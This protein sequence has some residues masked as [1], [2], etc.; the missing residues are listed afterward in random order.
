MLDNSVKHCSGQNRNGDTM[1]TTI[2]ITI[3]ED[4]LTT[5][6]VDG[7]MFFIKQNGHVVDNPDDN[8]V[9]MSWDSLTDFLSSYD[10]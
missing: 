8:A 6:Q 2:T 3:S 4:T 5:I 7:M 10:L 9:D 1:V